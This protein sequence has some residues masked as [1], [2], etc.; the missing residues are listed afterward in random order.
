MRRAT[1]ALIV[2]LGL[3]LVAC[4]DLRDFQGTWRGPRVGDSPVLKVGVARAATAALEIDMV[5]AHGLRGRL[6]VDGL[7]TGSPITSLAGAEADAIS[8][9]TFNGSPMRVYMAFVAVPDAGG[10]ALA[11]IALY[12]DRRVE[13]RVLRGGQ[14]P[15]YAIFALTEGS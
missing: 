2:T 9:M 10:E 6:S 14:V 7:M 12:D 1:L 15:L 13:V 11:M 4:N 3:A 5:D 8:G